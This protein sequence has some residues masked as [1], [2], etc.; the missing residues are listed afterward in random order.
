MPPLNRLPAAFR[1]AAFGAAFM[2][3]APAL[4]AQT[5]VTVGGSPIRI[6]SPPGFHEVSELSP[7]TRRLAETMTVPGNRLLAV[8][9]SEADLGRLMAG[10]PAKF[11]RYMMVQAPRDERP[12]SDSEFADLVGTVK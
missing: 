6:P 11:E 3:A 2:A 1:I 12:F 5:E 8:F 4:S 7:A 9:V 10:D